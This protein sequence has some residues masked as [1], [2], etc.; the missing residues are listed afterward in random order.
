MERQGELSPENLGIAKSAL[1]ELT[2][3]Y[4][5]LGITIEG[6]RVVGA[7]AGFEGFK[8]KVR[9]SYKADLQKQ[10]DALG[11]QIASMEKEVQNDEYWSMNADNAPA[12]RAS[13][14]L[15]RKMGISSDW[16]DVKEL[17]EQKAA[18]DQQLKDADIFF[19]T[20][21]GGSKQEAYD[22]LAVGAGGGMDANA[23]M[24]AIQ[25]GVQS[26]TDVKV[27]VPAVPVAEAGKDAAET[28]ESTKEIV[29]LTKRNNDYLQIMCDNI[30]GKMIYTYAQ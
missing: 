21:I 23:I 22:Q 28:A 26:V 15:A 24:G 18:V 1:E 5:D 8:G 27:E 10:S 6:N 3:T 25:S 19:G 14:W 20:A 12:K 13:V 2:K 7:S 9:Q 17:R 16:N 4:G 11:Q 30:V 29:N